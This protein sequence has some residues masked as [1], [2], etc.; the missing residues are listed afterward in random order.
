MKEL[1]ILR[2]DAASEESGIRGSVIEDPRPPQE[3]TPAL[4]EWLF[5]RYFLTGWD[6]QF[7]ERLEMVLNR[8]V[9]GNLLPQGKTFRMERKGVTVTAASQDGKTTMV[10]QTLKRLFNDGFT[11]T[12]CGEHI[13]YCR[14]RGDATVKSVCMDLCRTTGYYNFPSKLTRAEAHELATHRLRLAGVKILVID[15]AHNILGKNEPVNLF[16]KTLAQD[17]GGFSVILI[18]TP[19]VREFIYEK[20]ENIEMA[21]RYLDLPLLPFERPQ[22]VGL[23][24]GAV[25]GLARDAGVNLA[26]S[27]QVDPYFGDRDLRWLSR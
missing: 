12:K 4:V 14:L 17:G 23:I 19:K 2:Q 20:S 7:V 26:P 24:N 8:D 22:T 25:K 6:N 21:E 11:D 9:E 13:A 18:G 10:V 15:E 5:R 27:I 16:L 1:Q 3:D